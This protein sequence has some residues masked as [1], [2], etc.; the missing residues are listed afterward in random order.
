MRLHTQEDD[1]E[2]PVSLLESEPTA[3]D[4]AA[5]LL[6][7]SGDEEKPRC[8]NFRFLFRHLLVSTVLLPLCSFAFCVIWVMHEDFVKACYTACLKHG[9]RKIPNYLPS[10]SAATGDFYV[11]QV[12]WR[13]C[14]LLHAPPRFYFAFQYFQYLCKILPGR[15][16]PLSLVTCLLHCLEIS[17][18]VGLTVISSRMNFIMH[19]TCF[20]TFIVCSEIYMIAL[21]MLITSHTKF[22]RN[23]TSLE[24]R[25]LAVKKMLLK[26]ILLCSCALIYV[27]FRHEAYC[28]QGMYTLFSLLEYVIILS[29]IGFHATAYWDFYD[30]VVV[31]DR[32]CNRC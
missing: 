9:N 10:V 13:F 12:V 3:H 2:N 32:C 24:A 19:A 16:L 5:L 18:L 27:Y 7:K 15:H 22:S 8:F 6:E 14:I 17:G 29:N 21:C 20:G 31:I 26:I 1:P 23:A 28:E 4:D 11:S 25:S 30:K